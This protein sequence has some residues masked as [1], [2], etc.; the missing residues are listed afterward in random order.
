MN[1]VHEP[2]PTR[3]KIVKCVVWDLDETLWQGTLLEDGKVRISPAT[4]AAIRAL[5]ERGILQSIASKNDYDHATAALRR[6]GVDEFFLYKQISWGP[7]SSAIETIAARLNIGL[8]S[9]VFVDDQPFERDEV[10]HLLPS[11]T[12]I[13]PCSLAGLMATDEFVPMRITDETR[14]RRRMYMEDAARHR[15]EECFDGPRESFL[16]SLDM[17]FT[18]HR[19]RDTDLGRV[20]ELVARTNQLN[21][22]GKTYSLEELSF[23]SRS[24]KHEVWIASLADRYGDYGKIGVA[25]LERRDGAVVIKAFLMSCRV[26][27]RGVGSI[28]LQWIVNRAVR[29]GDALEAEWRQTGRNKMMLVTYR[30]MGFVPAGRRDDVDLLAYSGSAGGYPAY[31]DLR[32]PDDE[33]PAMASVDLVGAGGRGDVR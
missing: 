29:N 14:G 13:D 23:F 9:I 10:R 32:A 19:A 30:F 15:A 11:V 1:A 7:K 2:V 8:D 4:I 6:F 28:F 31:V 18:I 20:E 24:A 27:A 33:E 3:R 17:V 5:D 21:T 26:M 12:T 25:L 22:T 16:A